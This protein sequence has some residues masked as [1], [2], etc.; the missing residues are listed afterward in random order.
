MGEYVINKEKG[1]EIKIGVSIGT[2]DRCF[3][4][5][6]EELRKLIDMGYV[7][8]TISDGWNCLDAYLINPNT[9]YEGYQTAIEAQDEAVESLWDRLTDIP[10]DENEKKELIL[11][12]KWHIWDKGTIR[13]DIW[14]WFNK[15]HSK[16]V[17][18]LL[19]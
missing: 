1:L 3:L 17:Q 2:I 12:D 14:S 19:Y 9:I 15:N 16:G 10:F 11:T 18:Y 5:S 8:R 4:T 6:K 7:A 13:E